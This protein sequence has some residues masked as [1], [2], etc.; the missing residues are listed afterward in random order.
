MLK[1][2]ITRNSLELLSSMLNNEGKPNDTED[3]LT[4]SLVEKCIQSQPL[5]QMIIE[6][7][8]D[9]EGVLFEALHVNDELQ[10]VLSIYDE[11]EKEASIVEQDSSGPKPIEEEQ[12]C[13][14]D[15]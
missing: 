9:D 2:E 5:I 13:T 12:H 14:F 3:D 10:R 4:V 11:T 15:L 7:T 6:S 1:I 8:A